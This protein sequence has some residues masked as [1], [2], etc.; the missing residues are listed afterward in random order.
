MHATVSGI[1]LEKDLLVRW[2]RRV[3]RSRLKEK[4]KGLILCHEPGLEKMTSIAI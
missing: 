1:R 2:T 4:K 3:G